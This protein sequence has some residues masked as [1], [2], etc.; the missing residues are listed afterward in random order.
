MRKKA[1]DI[2]F[3]IMGIETRRVFSA[4]KKMLWV[5]VPGKTKANFTQ[6]G[7]GVRVFTNVRIS[8]FV[9]AA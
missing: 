3:Y 6:G 4:A 7:G 2:S 9:K 1:V 8:I 5:C